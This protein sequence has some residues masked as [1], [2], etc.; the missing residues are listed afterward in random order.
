MRSSSSRCVT[1][2]PGCCCGP[3]LMG[4]LLPSRRGPTSLDRELFEAVGGQ[5]DRQEPGLLDEPA[6]RVL[7]AD[8]AERPAGLDA[9]R[10]R[11]LGERDLYAGG[12]RTVDPL[13][14]PVEQ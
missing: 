14:R 8:V 3:S 4:R 13:D 1:R 7:G 11:A 12:E 9:Q 10:P 2:T 6:G 5:R